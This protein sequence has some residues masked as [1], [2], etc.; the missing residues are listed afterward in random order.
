MTSLGNLQ[1][2]RACKQCANDHQH[3]QPA[4]DPLER[5]ADEVANR[6]M[7]KQAASLSVG[8]VPS[9]GPAS[10]PNISAETQSKISNVTSSH[11]APLD[12]RIRGE[13]EPRF[14]Q[15]F[16]H[17]RIHTDSAA[18][19]SAKA[20]NAL[21]Y[22]T[23]NHLVFGS[24]QYSPSTGTGQRLLAH[25]LT[26][27]VQQ[28]NASQSLG[29]LKIQRYP[30]VASDVGSSDSV[31]SAASSQETCLPVSL[32]IDLAG[33]LSSAFGY[34]AETVIESDYC[35]TMG[36]SPA[37][38]Y[39]DNG[40][41]GPVDPAYAGFIIAHNSLASWQKVFLAIASVQRPDIL[42]DKPGI[43]DFFEIKPRSPAGMTKGIEKLLAIAAY[44][45]VLSLPYVWG[46]SYSPSFR[47]L[48]ASG[49]VLGTP[50]NVWLRVERIAPGLI[51]YDI[52]LE[53]DL[54]EILAKVSLAALLAAIIAAIIV[55]TE[56]GAAPVL[57]PLLATAPSLPAAASEALV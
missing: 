5:E 21:A 19:D 1:I 15:D 33:S 8:T 54:L 12:K 37:T 26:H 2:Q 40:L 6:V 14:G 30:G 35:N 17:V 7:R 13:L 3:I 22:T 32:L 45:S 50:L 24:G 28:D 29:A 42:V 11:G 55:V 36:C 56:G 39:F 31:A 38:E 41:A 4:D 48:L 47:K 46:T 44:M 18:A 52:C 10:T 51:V 16:S 23:G 9:S 20:V 34:F 49:P 25:E 27:T 43:R 53:G 57:I